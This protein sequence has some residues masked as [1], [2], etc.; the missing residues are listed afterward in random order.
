MSFDDLGR[1]SNGNSAKWCACFSHHRSEPVV[2]QG[3]GMQAVVIRVNSR[4]EEVDPNN[5]QRSWRGFL[6]PGS[7][8]S[9]L[10]DVGEASMTALYLS[11]AIRLTDVRKPR[12]NLF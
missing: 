11:S 12:I 5:A 10:S 3:P 1:L 6:I 9:P 4:Q 8:L 7:L 2:F